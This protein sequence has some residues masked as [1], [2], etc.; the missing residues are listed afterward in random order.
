MV[1]SVGFF[2]EKLKMAFD[3][4][5]YKVVWEKTKKNFVP[6]HRKLIEN[7]F[8][9][10]DKNFIVHHIDG[11]IL[12]NNINNLAIMTRSEHASLHHSQTALK[13]CG[14]SEYRKCFYCKNYDN[15]SEMMKHHSGG[16]F[17]YECKLEYLREYR[18]KKRMKG[19]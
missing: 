16:V 8:G 11:D 17:H 19:E 6:F 12:N 3:Q 4:H 9:K 10:L 2:L 7:I 14:N 15:P 13:A 1:G 5:G 18:R